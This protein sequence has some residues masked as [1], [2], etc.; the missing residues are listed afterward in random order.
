LRAA[1]NKYFHDHP[2]EIATALKL[3]TVLVRAIAQRH[4]MQPK[5]TRKLEDWTIESL[6]DVAAQFRP[7]DDDEV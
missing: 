4:R 2:D 1:L 5:E 3:L 6:K 7:P